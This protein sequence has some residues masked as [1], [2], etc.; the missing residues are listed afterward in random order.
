MP[1]NPVIPKSRANSAGLGNHIYPLV[2]CACRFVLAITQFSVGLDTYYAFE[3]LKQ[4]KNPFEG[5]LA[6]IADSR[7]DYS[8]V[9]VSDSSDSTADQNVQNKFFN[10]YLIRLVH[11]LNDQTSAFVLYPCI[12]TL[13]FLMILCIYD[14]FEIFQKRF[15]S[16]KVRKIGF[17]IQVSLCSAIVF[18]AILQGVIL[19]WH[20]GNVSHMEVL[21]P[22]IFSHGS[23]K[24][25]KHDLL[26]KTGSRD[27]KRRLIA[28]V[29]FNL[30]SL[31]PDTYLM[32]VRTLQPLRLYVM[33]NSIKVLSVM[34]MFACFIAGFIVKYSVGCAIDPKLMSDKTTINI[35]K[36][37]KNIN[38]HDLYPNTGWY[39]DSNIKNSGYI[40]D[41]YTYV[42][43]FDLVQAIN[44]RVNRTAKRLVTKEAYKDPLPKFFGDIGEKDENY[45]AL[46]TQKG[47]EVYTFVRASYDHV[48]H[49]YDVFLW[50]TFYVALL[51]TGLVVSN[52][53]LVV[54][55]HKLLLYTNVMIEAIAIALQVCSCF[56]AKYSMAG[57]DFFCDIKEYIPATTGANFES[58]AVYAWVCRSKGLFTIVL[59]FISIWIALC[60]GNLLVLYLL[61]R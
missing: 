15:S 28:C 19:V 16:K 23:S 37:N 29:L 49:V 50:V 35:M 2:L 38:V 46:D 36:H 12:I 11:F 47:L 5:S 55:R 40:G 32:L 41:D 34:T 44:S 54:K 48:L 20:N 24:N 31:V 51:S 61:W 60:V 33:V 14:L 52:F 39:V 53:L 26:L 57:A 13:C 1:S 42:P 17:W 7:I 30:A 56:M 3:S 9:P 45:G 4:K 22:F 43:V 21:Y 18:Q 6:S 59:S 25:A 8:W 58:M 27:L 10:Y